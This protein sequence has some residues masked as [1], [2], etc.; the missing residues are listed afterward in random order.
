MPRRTLNIVLEIPYLNYPVGIYKDFK[1]FSLNKA[2]VQSSKT[3]FVR[4][5]GN[6]VR[7][8]VKMFIV[9]KSYVKLYINK[10]TKNLEILSS[11]ILDRTIPL[12]NGII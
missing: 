2:I 1:A 8:Q 5:Y 11:V 3:S 7:E 9:K 4:P 6:K 10:N 12:E